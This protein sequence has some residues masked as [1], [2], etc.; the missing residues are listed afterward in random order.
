MENNRQLL[1]AY[2]MAILP[3]CD[4]DELQSLFADCGYKDITVIT[5]ADCVQAYDEC[6]KM[7][8]MPFGRIALRAYESP[9][10]EAYKRSIGINDDDEEEVI[11]KATSGKTSTLTDQEKQQYAL[12]WGKIASE[13]LVS[14]FNVFGKWNDSTANQQV[15]TPNPSTN[16]GNNGGN[17]SASPSWLMPVL[18]GGGALVAIVLILVVA[19]RK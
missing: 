8:Y 11:N 12:G 10:M 16:T 13:V 3:F 19:R 2:F 9:Q 17:S 5:A 4:R 7:F 14:G 18:I 6:G 1:R 15:V